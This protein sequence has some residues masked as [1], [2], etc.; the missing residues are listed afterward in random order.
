MLA[1][2]ELRQI[3]H[4]ISQSGMQDIEI[5]GSHYRVRMRC[6]PRRPQPQPQAEPQPV[7]QAEPENKIIT[8]Q[9]PGIIWFTHPLNGKAIS[10]PGETVKPGALL[11][12]LSIGHLM[13]PVRSPV[14][15]T[16]LEHCAAN[17]SVVEYGSELL[18]LAE[19][20]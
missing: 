12:L 14:G 1:I 10:T 19:N 11:A 3:A 13:L 9:R 2:A 20:D 6:A 5:A 18:A 7:A 17:G 4:K 8:A 16:L 15:G